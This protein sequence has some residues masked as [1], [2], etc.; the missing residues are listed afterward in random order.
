LPLSIK[1][2]SWDVLAA[3]HPQLAA[4]PTFITK[5]FEA[6]LLPPPPGAWEQPD[7]KMVA[8]VFPAYEAGSGSATLTPLR[9]FDALTR[10]LADRIWLGYPLE[11]FR[12][13]RFLAWLERMPAY[14][15]RYEHMD[16][17]AEALR[18]LAA[19]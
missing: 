14:R 9:P 18:T 13:R 7:A 8:L 12:V 10:L 11:E 17:A 15:L 2:G 6:K 5:S 16:D 19:P 3:D 1:R 4:R